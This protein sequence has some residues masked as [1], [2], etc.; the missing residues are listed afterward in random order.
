MEYDNT[1]NSRDEI[2][3]IDW[4]RKYE[5]MD[6]VEYVKG[7]IK[8]RKE[9]SAFRMR[10]VDEIKDSLKFID[11]P[12]NSV[13]YKLINLNDSDAKEIIVIHNANE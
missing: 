3:K 7:L 12:A 13:A 9:Y 4:F 5:N 1:Y 6:T 11:A 2:N 10:T 8:L